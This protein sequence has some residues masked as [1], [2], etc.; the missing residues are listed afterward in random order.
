MRMNL[1]FRQKQVFI[2]QIFI[3]LIIWLSTTLCMGY[4]IEKKMSV[5]VN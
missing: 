2:R 3:N 1:N 5:F 4:H